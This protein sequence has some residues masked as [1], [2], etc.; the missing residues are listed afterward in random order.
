M[1]TAYDEAVF[2]G[3]KSRDGHHSVD[4]LDIYEATAMVFGE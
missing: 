2:C 3:L 4:V 1:R